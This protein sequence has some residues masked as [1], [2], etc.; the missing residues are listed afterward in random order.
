MSMSNDSLT[1]VLDARPFELKEE[2][3]VPL[4]KL[5]CLRNSCHYDQPD[6]SK[7]LSE[8]RFRPAKL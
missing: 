2:Q 7:V 4:F 8:E 6:V 5:T 1:S 3:K